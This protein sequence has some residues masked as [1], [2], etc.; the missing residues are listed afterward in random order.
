MGPVLC[1]ICDV[2]F[3]RSLLATVSTSCGGWFGL[4]F[5]VW[6]ILFT[7]PVVPAVTI[8]IA[9]TLDWTSKAPRQ[10][11]SMLAAHACSHHAL[12]GLRFRLLGS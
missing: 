11:L 6:D 8:L 2:L 9:H 12:P 10:A 5:V 3:R 7:S 1:P 4:V